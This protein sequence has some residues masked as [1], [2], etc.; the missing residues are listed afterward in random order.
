MATVFSPLV[1]V[2]H[3]QAA[4]ASDPDPRVRAWMLGTPGAPGLPVQCTHTL[5]A[6][7]TDA[8]TK[9]ADK[10]PEH[11]VTQTHPHTQL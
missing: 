5:T 11:T 8:H 2:L 1:L 7:H 6:P 3:V 9:H 10:Y 4:P